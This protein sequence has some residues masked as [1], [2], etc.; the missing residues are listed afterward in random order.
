MMSGP[1]RRRVQI[2]TDG[3]E[4][5]Q[6]LGRALGRVLRAGDSVLLDGPLG[7]G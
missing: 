2:E 1:A 5:T 7:A 4:F 3:P 6:D